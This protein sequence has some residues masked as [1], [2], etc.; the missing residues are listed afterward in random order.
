MDAYEKD[1][2]A[3]AVLPQMI[4]ES[5]NAPDADHVPPDARVALA[6]SRSYAYADAMAVE[7]KK[8][9]A[10]EALQDIADVMAEPD[11]RRFPGS[12]L[13][14][15]E[16][17]RELGDLLGD[18]RNFIDDVRTEYPAAGVDLRARIDRYVNDFKPGG[19]DVPFRPDVTP[20]R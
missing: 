10:E 11:V 13:M 9:R 18:L 2:I 14:L 12:V 4:A 5:Y 16:D 19:L 7:S 17:M 3:A 6:V 8:R 1:A 20:V 15:P